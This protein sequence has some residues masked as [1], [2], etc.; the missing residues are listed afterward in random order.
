MRELHVRVLI[1]WVDPATGAAGPGVGVGKAIQ[2]SDYSRRVDGGV[3]LVRMKLEQVVKEMISGD[4]VAKLRWLLQHEWQPPV[5]S[6][7][8][9]E[10]VS[11]TPDDQPPA[12]ESRAVEETLPATGEPSVPGPRAATTG[13]SEG[14]SGEQNPEERSEGGP[15]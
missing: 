4:G 11:R 8:A 5:S 15:G 2:E 14:Q 9:G 3:V 13:V 10:P 6:G 12:P 1:A 7:S